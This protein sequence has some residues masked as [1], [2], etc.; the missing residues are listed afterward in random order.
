MK[1]WDRGI[2]VESAAFWRRGQGGKEKGTSVL[3]HVKKVV[4][5]GEGRKFKDDSIWGLC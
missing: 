1:T 3:G 4:L 5:T 2:G